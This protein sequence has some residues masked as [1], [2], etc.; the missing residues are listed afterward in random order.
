MHFVPIDPARPIEE[1]VREKPPP[2]LVRATVSAP[3]ARTRP[4]PAARALP[5]PPATPI[6][7]TSF[8]SP[9]LTLPLPPLLSLPSPQPGHPFD[10]VLQK[11]PV[12]SPHK[13]DWDAR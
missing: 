5:S 8:P 10:V 3:R 4:P 2:R 11:V 13:T 1:Q 12:S 6:A 9:T 7:F